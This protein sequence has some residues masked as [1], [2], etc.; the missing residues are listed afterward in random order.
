[1]GETKEKIT[2][3][4]VN[5]YTVCSKFSSFFHRKVVTIMNDFNAI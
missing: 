3:Y 5:D 1:M 2:S 4:E